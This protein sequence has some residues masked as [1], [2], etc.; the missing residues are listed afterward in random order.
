M[1]IFMKALVNECDFTDTKY[2][3]DVEG[4]WMLAQ[5]ASGRYCPVMFCGPKFLEEKGIEPVDYD[6]AVSMVESIEGAFVDF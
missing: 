1:T 2:L 3:G 4:A 5:G 6:T